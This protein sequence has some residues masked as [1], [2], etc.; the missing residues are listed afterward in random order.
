MTE[1]YGDTYKVFFKSLMGQ[2]EKADSDRNN[3]VHWIVMTSHRGGKPVDPET[4]V[5]LHHIHLRDRAPFTKKDVEDF[6]EHAD[7]LRLLV[8]YFVQYLMFGSKIDDKDEWRKVFQE[9]VVYPPP[10]NH[11]LVRMKATSSGP[12]AAK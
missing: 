5:A 9:K 10:P 11:P 4:D 8:F 2:Q 7:F 6:T 3:V 1:T 12:P